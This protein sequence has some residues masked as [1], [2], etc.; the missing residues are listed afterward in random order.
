L[1]Y[2]ISIFIKHGKKRKCIV[3]ENGSFVGG[4]WSEEK[5]VGW[6]FLRTIYFYGDLPPAARLNVTYLS[7]HTFPRKSFIKIS[8][9]FY[10]EQFSNLG[11]H[12]SF[13]LAFQP[14]NSTHSLSSSHCLRLFS[15]RSHPALRRTGWSSGK[16][17][18]VVFV[19]VSNIYQVLS[20][21]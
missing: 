12:V 7:Q 21:S 20:K 18:Q 11:P 6:D 8:G 1:W 14:E 16:E 13:E 19:C 3:R 2:I 15:A 9:I 10:S 4:L 5:F 17:S